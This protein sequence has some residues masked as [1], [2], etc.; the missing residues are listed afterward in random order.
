MEDAPPSAPVDAAVVDAAERGARFP[1]QVDP[2]VRVEARKILIR[3][4][5]C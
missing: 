3:E 1:L 5:V 4:V 2:E